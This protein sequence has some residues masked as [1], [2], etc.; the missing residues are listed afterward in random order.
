M[1]NIRRSK[2]VFFK[3]VATFT[4]GWVVVGSWALVLPVAHTSFQSFGALLF[5]ASQ[6]DPLTARTFYPLRSS[7]FPF[8]FFVVFVLRMLFARSLPLLFVREQSHLLGVESPLRRLVD[9]HPCGGGGRHL[10]ASGGAAH[11][12]K[13]R[14]RNVTNDRYTSAF[15]DGAKLDHGENGV[16][17]A[18][19]LYSAPPASRR[20]IFL[21]EFET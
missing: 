3:V 8:L 18:K 13:V 16:S 12:S 2:K 21:F 10:L 14:P 19:G 11:A 1:L 7:S 20:Q 5:V 6:P 15:D 9:P 17:A 4:A